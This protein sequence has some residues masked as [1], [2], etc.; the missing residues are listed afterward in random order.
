MKRS[1]TGYAK[2][3]PWEDKWPALLDMHDAAPAAGRGPDWEAALR[4]AKGRDAEA[5]SQLRE[6][7]EGTPLRLVRTRWGLVDLEAPT[8]VGEDMAL[9]LERLPGTFFF[10]GGGEGAPHHHPQFDLDEEV[11]WRGTAL[12]VRFALDFC[13]GAEVP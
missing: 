1:K 3:A 5:I 11:L 4:E 7:L 2:L 12:F 9:Y 8:L 13:S 6:M 10:L